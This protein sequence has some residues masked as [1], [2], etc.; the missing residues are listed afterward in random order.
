MSQ[1]K[2]HEIDFRINCELHPCSNVAKYS[3]GQEGS[4]K[5]TWLHLC[6]EC[7]DALIGNIITEHAD[8]VEKHLHINAKAEE[9]KVEEPVKYDTLTVAELKDIAISEGIPF[10]TRSTK[11]ELIEAIEAGKHE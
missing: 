8:K 3:I 2:L 1:T 5:Y 6:E 7:A 11:A 10:N 9:P 4:S